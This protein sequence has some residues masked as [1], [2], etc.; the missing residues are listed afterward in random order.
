[1]L[2]ILLIGDCWLLNINY[3]HRTMKS[4]LVFG[5]VIAITTNKFAYRLFEDDSR[6][7]PR[8]GEIKL[9]LR[10]FDV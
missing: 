2:L 6:P 5:V 1:M 7:N 3:I 8:H 4:N 10:V 9:V